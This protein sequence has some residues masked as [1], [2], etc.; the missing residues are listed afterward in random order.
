[1]QFRYSSVFSSWKLQSFHCFQPDS[2]ADIADLLELA[3][4]LLQDLSEV[5]KTASNVHRDEVTKGRFF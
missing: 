4:P 1:M 3:V 5:K 2:D